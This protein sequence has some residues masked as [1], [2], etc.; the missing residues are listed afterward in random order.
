MKKV[1]VCLRSSTGIPFD[2]EVDLIDLGFA[3]GDYT[4]KVLH[5][6][7]HGL[8][9]EQI[10]APIMDIIDE[11]SKMKVKVDIDSSAKPPIRI[12]PRP[13]VGKFRTI[14]EV[15]RYLDTNNEPAAEA[16]AAAS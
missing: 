10:E 7:L 6:T 5:D 15:A 9:R 1:F 3:N 13:G 14:I 11:F 2:L 16:V 4:E 8:S 12:T